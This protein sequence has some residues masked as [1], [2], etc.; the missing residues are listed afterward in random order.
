MIQIFISTSD[1]LNVIVVGLDEYLRI[2]RYLLLK[3]RLILFMNLK[4]FDE[5]LGESNTEIRVQFCTN[6]LNW[7]IFNGGGGGIFGAKILN[8]SK[9]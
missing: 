7:S 1:K 2:I 9:V 8:L 6:H 3:Y 4:V 5:P